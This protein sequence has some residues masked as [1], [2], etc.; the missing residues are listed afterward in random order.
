MVWPA[1]AN[2]DLAMLRIGS[3]GNCQSS[4][5]DASSLDLYMF[6]SI[7][8]NPYVTMS[9]LRRRLSRMTMTRQ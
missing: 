3:R 4:T 2:D 8:T 7:D 9:S 6:S 5:S 1:S